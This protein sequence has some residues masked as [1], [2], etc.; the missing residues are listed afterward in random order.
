MSM[1]ICCHRTICMT[2]LKLLMLDEDGVGRDED[3]R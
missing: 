3:V 2:M 1:I